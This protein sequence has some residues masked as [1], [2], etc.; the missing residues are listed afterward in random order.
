MFA[1]KFTYY[2]KINNKYSFMN[3]LLTGAIDIIKTKDLE[4]LL[5]NDFKLSKKLSKKNNIT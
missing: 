1:S 2:Y 3:N 5:A 4:K